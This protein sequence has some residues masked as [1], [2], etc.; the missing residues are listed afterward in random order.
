[1]EIIKLTNKDIELLKTYAVGMFM[2]SLLDEWG[3][4]ERLGVIAK[5]HNV[6]TKKHNNFHAQIRDVNINKKKKPSHK[7]ILFIKA[8][9]IANTAWKQVISNTEKGI[10][11]SS[12]IVIHNLYRHNSEQFSLIYGLKETDFINLVLFWKRYYYIYRKYK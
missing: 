10:S 7:C 5:I 2:L 12:N 11:I 3:K 1:M 9:S 6:I 8:S 4:I